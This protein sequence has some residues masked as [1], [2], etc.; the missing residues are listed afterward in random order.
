MSILSSSNTWKYIALKHSHKAK[1][2]YLQI[3]KNTQFF[4]KQK[5]TIKHKI[6]NDFSEHY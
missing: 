3:I 5:S 4:F 1:Y 2:N 6:T